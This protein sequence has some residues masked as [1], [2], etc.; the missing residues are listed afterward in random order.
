[1]QNYNITES[2]KEKVEVENIGQYCGRQGGGESGVS[3]RRAI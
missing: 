2:W 3:V 1:M